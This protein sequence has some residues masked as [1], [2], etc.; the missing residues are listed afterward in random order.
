MPSYYQ[1]DYR[2]ENE[3]RLSLGVVCE[4]R[5]Y[6]FDTFQAYDHAM[7]LMQNNPDFTELK[8]AEDR[9]MV[10]AGWYY[11][12]KR[13]ETGSIVLYSVTPSFR[14]RVDFANICDYFR[15]AVYRR[16]SRV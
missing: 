13:E 10:M 15:K 5:R 8:L 1:A 3:Q 12:F 2:I 9:E 7:V 14:E 4:H 16:R 6:H 11:E